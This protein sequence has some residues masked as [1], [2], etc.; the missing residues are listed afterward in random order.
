[1]NNKQDAYNERMHQIRGEVLEAS[2]LVSHVVHVD[3]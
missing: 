2:F 3:Q 1:M